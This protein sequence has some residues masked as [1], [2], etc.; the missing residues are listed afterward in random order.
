MPISLQRCGQVSIVRE[1]AVVLVLPSGGNWFSPCL[2]FVS[3]VDP[4]D[5]LTGKALPS[6]A[7]GSADVPEVAQVASQTAQV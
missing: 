4:V 1:T 2:L 5:E 3:P 7:D 6:V